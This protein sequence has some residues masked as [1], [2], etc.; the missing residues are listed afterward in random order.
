M[1]TIAKV[2]RD[3]FVHD[4]GIKRISRERGLSRNS[5]RKILRCGETAF[6]YERLAQPLPKLGAYPS[7]ELNRR[8]RSALQRI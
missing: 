5:V 7:V 1:E 3:H 6:S 2:R 8:R 4:K